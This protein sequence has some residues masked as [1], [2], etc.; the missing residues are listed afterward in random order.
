MGASTHVQYALDMKG[1]Q[2]NW[3]YLNWSYFVLTCNHSAFESQEFETS[4]SLKLMCCRW[5]K[6]LFDYF[7][8]GL[9]GI[10]EKLKNTNSQSRHYWFNFNLSCTGVSVGCHTVYTFYP[11]LFLCYCCFEWV[12]YVQN[13]FIEPAYSHSP[14]LIC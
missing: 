7:M 14:W 9:C 11:F 3:E 10:V 6:W 1:S 8:N 4:V 12:I 13:I 2:K 5:L